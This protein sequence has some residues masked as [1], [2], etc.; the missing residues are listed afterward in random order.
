MLAGQ[1]SIPTRLLSASTMLVLIVLVGFFAVPSSRAATTNINI[2][3]FS[4]EPA[5]VTIAVGD[6][7]TW[8]NR[9]SFAHTVTDNVGQ[10]PRFDTGPIATNQSSSVRFD[11]PGTFTY[12]CTIHSG[13]SGT[14]V[15]QAASSGQA[16]F[17]PS[18]AR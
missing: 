18:V 6:T 10:P 14:V 4:F 15:V 16:V 8:T 1:R 3:D 11:T 2:V 12:I 13:M 5:T 9:D 7:V 17:L